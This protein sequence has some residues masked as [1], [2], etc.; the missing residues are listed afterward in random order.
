MVANKAFLARASRA[1]S[2]KR[3]CLHGHLLFEIVSESVSRLDRRTCCSRWPAQ[4][5]SHDRAQTNFTGIRCAKEQESRAQ[6]QR[7][8]WAERYRR[9]GILARPARF[10]NAKRFRPGMCFVPPLQG[11]TFVGRLPGAHAPGLHSFALRAWP[12]RFTPDCRRSRPLAAEERV[13]NNRKTLTK[14]AFEAAPTVISDQ[15]G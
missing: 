7:N 13:R 4:S 14:D 5:A 2:L 1:K 8:G 10:A 9:L 11:S 3:A 6:G 15:K 12:K